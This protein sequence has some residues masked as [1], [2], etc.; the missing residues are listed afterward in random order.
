MALHSHHN[1]TN[2]KI[3]RK[4]CKYTFYYTKDISSEGIALFSIAIVA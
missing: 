4:L 3:K 2:I 1:Q